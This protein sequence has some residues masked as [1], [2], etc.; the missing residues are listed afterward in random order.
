MMN[1]NL[2]LQGKI[3]VNN[4]TQKTIALLAQKGGGK[5]TLIR[6]IGEKLDGKLPIIIL[7]PVGGTSV[8]SA[9]FYQMKVTSDN[10][11]GHTMKWL[12][13]EWENKS[14]VLIDTSRLN[15]PDYVEWAEAF[16]NL[17]WLKD[18]LI[19]VD[20]THFLVPQMRGKYCLNF[21][22]FVKVCRND[23]VGVIVSSQRPQS[24]SKEILA[25]TDQ[26][27][28]GRIVYTSDREIALSLIEPFI[29]KE[30]Y[31]QYERTIQE[32]GFMEFLCVDYQSKAQK[33]FDAK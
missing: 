11:T 24:V 21:Q 19:I 23:N 2:N 18:G 10:L 5:S 29:T 1:V 9:K 12:K 3:K 25:L 26:Y 30:Q 17:P 28:I 16:F 4:I 20:E 7:D 6:M 22:K 13:K 33:E 15:T 8:Q 31:V 14:T 32:F 27:I